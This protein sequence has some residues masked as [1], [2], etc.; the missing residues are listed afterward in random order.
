MLRLIATQGSV[1]AQ[2]YAQL[3]KQIAKLQQQADALRNSEVKGVIERIKV[4]ITH[5]GLS[6]EQLGFGGAAPKASGRTKVKAAT[7]AKAGVSPRFSDGPGRSWSG[8]GPRPHWLRDALAAGR[9]LEEFSADR[10]ASAPIAT[11]EATPTASAPAKTA[12]TPKT[13][14]KKSGA[15]KTMPEMAKARYA[16]DAG[17][18]WSGRGPKPAWLKEQLAAGKAISDFERQA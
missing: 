2:T 6:P 9:S 7:A 11:V 5:Y 17:H 8:R 1:M 16:D 10:Q 18:S 15:K 3:Q 13:K 12:R 14:A 4:A